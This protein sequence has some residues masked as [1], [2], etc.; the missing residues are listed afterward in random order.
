[1]WVF[2]QLHLPGPHLISLLRAW[3]GR[4]SE[5]ESWFF[6]FWT[7]L[8]ELCQEKIVS[9][10]EVGCLQEN[11]KESGGRGSTRGASVKGKETVLSWS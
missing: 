1:M 7:S 2:S 10:K 5:A 6:F 9:G 3:S 11:K 4:V 8:I